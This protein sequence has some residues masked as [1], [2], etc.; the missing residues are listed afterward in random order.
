MADPRQELADIIV[1]SAPAL[2]TPAGNPL[3]LWVAGGLV[4]VACVMLLAWLWHRHRPTRALHAIATAAVQQQSTPSTLAAQLDAWVR[5]TF[6]LAR[7]DAATCPPGL[8]PGV[9][10]EWAKALEHLRFA[11]PQPDGFAVLVNLCESAR[12]WRRHA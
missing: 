1:P 5:K 8:D 2:A 11:P 9:W 12:Q 3:F 7:V 4:C 10:S 6:Q